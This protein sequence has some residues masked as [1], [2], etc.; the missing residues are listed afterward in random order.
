LATTSNLSGIDTL[1]GISKFFVKQ[2]KLTWIT[3]KD[4][5]TNILKKLGKNYSSFS[6]SSDFLTYLSG[7]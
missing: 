7:T 2:N 3:P 4:F 5:E 6:T 1:S